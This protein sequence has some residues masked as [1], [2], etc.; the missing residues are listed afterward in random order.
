MCSKTNAGVQPVG[1]SRHVPGRASFRPRGRS[2]MHTSVRSFIPSVRRFPYSPL[3]RR[4]SSVR[5]FGRL[6]IYPAL[7]TIFDALRSSNREKGSPSKIGPKPPAGSMRAPPFGTAVPIAGRDPGSAPPKPE[8]S[9]VGVPAVPSK[10]EFRPSWPRPGP[11]LSTASQTPGST[12]AGPDPRPA[13]RRSCRSAVDGRGP[14][15]RPILRI[16]NQFPKCAVPDDRARGLP[17][18][19][20][21]GSIP[22]PIRRRGSKLGFDDFRATH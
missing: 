9:C 12:L 18:S 8:T 13:G 22:R 3:W 16:S 4:L 6:A 7:V 5:S 15:G 19:S 2:G 1:R 20:D 14:I 21:W 10:S 17:Q 11:E